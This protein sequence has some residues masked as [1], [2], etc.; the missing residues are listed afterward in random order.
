MSIK[1]FNCNRYKSRRSGLT[2]EDICL[3]KGLVQIFVLIYVCFLVYIKVL[4]GTLLYFLTFVCEMHC[5]NCSICESPRQIVYF[6][7]Q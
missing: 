7:G 2:L 5:Y 6:V 3:L 4:L 1:H